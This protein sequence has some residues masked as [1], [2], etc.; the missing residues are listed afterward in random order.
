MVPWNLQKSNY[1]TG[2]PENTVAP[3]S[4]RPSEEHH[5]VINP[6]NRFTIHHKT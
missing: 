3:D 6:A 2:S 5:K 4:S 1:Q